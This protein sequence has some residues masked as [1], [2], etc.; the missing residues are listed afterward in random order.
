[1][2]ARWGP[3]ATPYS[4]LGVVPRKPREPVSGKTHDGENSDRPNERFSVAAPEGANLD[5]L[6]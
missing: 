6:P 1:M 4:C 5:S 3:S 2:N